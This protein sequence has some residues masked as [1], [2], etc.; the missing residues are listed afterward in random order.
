VVVSPTKSKPTTKQ[1]NRRRGD[2]Y[3]YLAHPIDKM[4]SEARATKAV[5]LGVKRVL[6]ACER[7]GLPVFRP[8]QAWTVG[9]QATPTSAIRAVNCAAVDHAAALVAVV[10]PAVPTWGVPSEIERAI[11]AGTPVLVILAGQDDPTW[12]MLYLEDEAETWLLDATEIDDI[13]DWLEP[14]LKRYARPVR[15]LPPELDN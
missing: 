11:A 14:R 7:I 10:H 12:A 4:A 13:V 9:P 5:N 1:R 2:P 8:A 3:V 6:W 15:P